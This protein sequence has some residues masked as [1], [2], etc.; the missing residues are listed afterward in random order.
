MAG[1]GLPLLYPHYVRYRVYF[2]DERTAA[3]AG[4]RVGA[5]Q[6]VRCGD[7]RDHWTVAVRHDRWS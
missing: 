3:A 4:Y 6:V 7:L 5:E 2:A 1:L